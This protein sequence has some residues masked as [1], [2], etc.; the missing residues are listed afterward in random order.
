[1]LWSLIKILLF[2]AVIAGLTLG[3]GQLLEI[4]SGV[5]VV[6]S[7]TEYSPSSLQMVIAAVLLLL[8]VWYLFCLF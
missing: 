4:E 1:M 6:V 7:G 3:A 8:V 2:V 5:R